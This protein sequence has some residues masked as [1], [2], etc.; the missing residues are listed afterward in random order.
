MAYVS[1]ASYLLIIEMVAT[2]R[3]RRLKELIDCFV[4]LEEFVRV[5]LRRIEVEKVRDSTFSIK[6][7]TLKI[8]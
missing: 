3:D 1:F 5:T 4:C 8:F 6:I 2:K 7:D